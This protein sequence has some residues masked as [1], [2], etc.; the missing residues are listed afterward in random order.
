MYCLENV[1][2]VFSDDDDIQSTARVRRESVATLGGDRVHFE[3][4]E[5]DRYVHDYEQ[6]DDRN[7]RRPSQYILP[8]STR[9]SVEKSSPDTIRV[10]CF[11][12]VNERVDDLSGIASC[13]EVEGANTVVLSLDEVEISEDDRS[14]LRESS[15]STYMPIASAWVRLGKN[16]DVPGYQSLS[17]IERSAAQMLA[18]TLLELTLTPEGYLI[19]ANKGSLCRSML[20]NAAQSLPHVLG[21]IVNDID[22][23]KVPADLLDE[24][25]SKL[26]A[27]LDKCLTFKPTRSFFHDLFQLD[28]I[29]SSLIAPERQVNISIGVIMLTSPEFR[30]IISRA[31]RLIPESGDKEICLTLGTPATLDVPSIMGMVQKFPVDLDKLLPGKNTQSG[32]I[33]IKYHHVIFAVLKAC[34]RST[35][36]AT[37]LDSKPLFNAFLEMGDELLM[38]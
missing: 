5:D 31:V 14:V 3:D 22:H 38:G 34:L 12:E 18:K 6:L 9:R 36:I 24:V 17:F 23:L 25:V 27:F 4:E 35:V 28:N 19:N 7:P 2:Y 26:E 33:Q 20:C 10:F 29:L 16:R 1:D 30:D 32:T 21:R 15:S 11:N 37:S 13:L 8:S